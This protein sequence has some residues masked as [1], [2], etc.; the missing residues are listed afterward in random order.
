MVLHLNL[1]GDENLNWLESKKA[2]VTCEYKDSITTINYK[3]QKSTWEGAYLAKFFSCAV[4]D[5]ELLFV[6]DDGKRLN[7]I[8]LLHVKIKDNGS[9]SSDILMTIKTPRRYIEGDENSLRRFKTNFPIIIPPF[10]NSPDKFGIVLQ[11]MDPPPEEMADNEYFVTQFQTNTVAKVV[12]VTRYKQCGAINYKQWSKFKNEEIPK[13][14]FVGCL[15]DL[16][17]EKEVKVLWF[18]ISDDFKASVDK[19]HDLH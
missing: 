8:H 16:K 17:L 15:V 18:T 1:M 19:A 7:V 9:M 2:T 14:H 3:G 4:E 5:G 12:G 10:E 11:T 6:R 13:N